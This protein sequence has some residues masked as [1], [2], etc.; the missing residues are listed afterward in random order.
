[1]EAFIAGD[2]I[3]SAG[4]HLVVSPTY[5]SEDPEQA[6]QSVRRLID[7]NLKIEHILVG[8]G[9]DVY[10]GASQNLGRIFTGPRAN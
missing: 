2:S 4:E 6:A 10:A 3:L 8:H 7:M 5:L 9:D 1:M